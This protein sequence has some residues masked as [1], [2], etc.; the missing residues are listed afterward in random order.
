MAYGVLMHRAD[1][2]YDDHPEARYQFP[3]R[4]LSRAM[5]MAGDWVLYLEPT[6]VKNSRGYFAVAQVEAVVPDLTASGMHLALIAP[7]TFL[8]FPN[9]VAFSGKFGPVERGLLHAMGQLGGNKQ[10]ALRTLSAEDFARIVNLGLGRADKTL[11]RVDHDQP[12]ESDAQPTFAVAEPTAAYTFDPERQRIPNL[13]SRWFRDRAFR[14]AVLNAYD[15]RCALTGLQLING[16]GRAEAEA[17][18]IRPVAEG[19][20][21]TISN[22]IALSG[23]VHWMFDRGLISLDDDL[24]I[25]VSRQVNDAQ[26]LHRLL[27]ANG[28]AHAPILAANRPHPTYLA[29]HRENT[30]KA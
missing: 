13:G 14:S 22:G 5:T 28:M 11:P 8:P 2:I 10:S 15:R 23:T 20:Q 16:G 17:A 18:H 1:S 25:L 26:G 7:G 21:D 6:K 12:E 3:D 19:G 29:W 9:P 4:Y 24:R 27:N 30:F